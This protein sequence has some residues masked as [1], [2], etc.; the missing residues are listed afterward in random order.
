VPLSRRYRNTTIDYSFLSRLTNVCFIGLKEEYEDFVK[1]QNLPQLRYQ[2]C[3]DALEFALIVASSAVF[4]GNQ[5]FGFSVAEGLKVNRALEACELVPN[6]VPTGRGAGS[7]LHQRG[8]SN[9]LRGFGVAV[10]GEAEIGRPPAFT[11]YLAD[12]DAPLSA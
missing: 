1:R 2:E 9:L 4:I 8:L 7:F 5:S 6:I 11:L 3:R 12:G 10:G